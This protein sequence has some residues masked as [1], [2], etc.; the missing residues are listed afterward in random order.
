MDNTAETTETT[1]T[2]EGA[3]P[4]PPSTSPMQRRV[5]MKL[6]IDPDDAS[7]LHELLSSYLAAINN[8]L[9]TNA[10]ALASSPKVL[11]LLT[12]KR[13][14]AQSLLLRFTAALSTIITEE[15]TAL[16]EMIVAHMQQEAKDRLVRAQA[17]LDAEIEAKAEVEKELAAADADTDTAAAGDTGDSHATP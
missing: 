5:V 9:T 17:S 4:Q 13:D 12:A 15:A 10:G 16:S 3:Q 1:E 11:A 2:A 7:L 8:A 14:T 6:P